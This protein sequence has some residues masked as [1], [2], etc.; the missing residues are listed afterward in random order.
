MNF[1]NGIFKAPDKSKVIV[2]N[3]AVGLPIIIAPKKFLLSF[4]SNF[5]ILDLFIPFLFQ[6][7]S[8]TDFLKYLPIV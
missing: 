3:G 6:Y 8:K 1:F 2:D 4:F 7:F 5:C